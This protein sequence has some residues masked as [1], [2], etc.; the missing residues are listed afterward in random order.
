MIF[1]DTNQS[2]NPLTIFFKV[3]ALGKSWGYSGQKLKPLSLELVLLCQPSPRIASGSSYF[4][5]GYLRSRR[6]SWRTVVDFAL[7]AL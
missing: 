4:T 6:H 5:W 1:L 3:K 2:T 7:E